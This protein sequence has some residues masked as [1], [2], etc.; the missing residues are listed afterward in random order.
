MDK[1]VIVSV[2]IVGLL[3][4]LVAGL[5]WA[6]DG[7]ENAPPAAVASVSSPST[8]TTNYPGH[9]GHRYFEQTATLDLGPVT[10]GI[11]YCACIDDAHAP[12]VGNLEGYLGMP[13]PHACN[14]YHGG[15]M[16]IVINGQ[17][18]GLARLSSMAAVES[19]ERAIVDFV[20]HHQL[21]DVRAR[22]LG[23]PGEDRIYC[24]VA[25]EPK[26]EIRSIEVPLVCYPSFFTAWHGRNGARRV[27]TP[28]ALVVEGEKQAL[29]A[30]ENWWAVYYDEVFDIARHEGEGPCAMLVLPTEAQEVHFQ[31]QSYPCL[32]TIVFS[33]SARRLRMAFWDFVD[34][35][36]ADVLAAMPEEAAQA[37]RFLETA[38]FTPA[39]FRLVGAAETLAEVEEALKRPEVREQLGAKAD[40]IEK[41]LAD[42]RPL[43]ADTALR[44]TIAG[45]ERLAVA[46]QRFNEFVWELKIA[47]LL[48]F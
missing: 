2:R 3:A 46:V 10:Y 11:K 20:W 42:T 24:E 1:Q 17:D 23:L 7:A 47:E 22:F 29:P 41:W 40:E 33:P 30:N 18:V 8:T 27:R 26:Q 35:T 37:R 38:D 6:A 19:G 13:L 21:A 34:R 12:D 36:N 31:P 48:D 16:R 44:Q 25:I 5:G 45:Q 43:L 4:I 39:G 15:F 14:W 9:E 32:T 28:A